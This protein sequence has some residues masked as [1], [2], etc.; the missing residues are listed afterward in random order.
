[1]CDALAM[2]T[3]RNTGFAIGKFSDRKQRFA[4]GLMMRWQIPIGSH[5]WDLAEEK[6]RQ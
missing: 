2:M 3:S 1:M 4:P 6:L 5:G